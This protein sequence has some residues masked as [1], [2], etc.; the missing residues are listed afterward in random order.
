[1]VRFLERQKEHISALYLERFSAA[2]LPS[3]FQGLEVPVLAPLFKARLEPLL[4]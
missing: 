3:D 4:V 2:K 1:M